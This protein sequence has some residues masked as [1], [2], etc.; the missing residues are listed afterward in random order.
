MNDQEAKLALAEARALLRREGLAFMIAAELAE[1]AL[2]KAD[3]AKRQFDRAVRAF[4][5]ASEEVAP[6]TTN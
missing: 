4:V 1:D 2:L 5:T 3:M 6:W